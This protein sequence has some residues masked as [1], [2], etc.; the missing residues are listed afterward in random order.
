VVPR[1]CQR[2]GR[3]LNGYRADARYCGSGCRAAAWRAALAVHSRSEWTPE[4]AE[5]FIQAALRKFPG[6]YELPATRGDRT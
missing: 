5:D 2:C 6:S 4:A 3:S 1:R